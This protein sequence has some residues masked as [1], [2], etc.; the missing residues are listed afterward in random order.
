MLLVSFRL[1]CLWLA[2][3][4]LTSA[5]VSH[6]GYAISVGRRLHADGAAVCSRG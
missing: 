6:T 4:F 3:A 1:T 2:M 5:E